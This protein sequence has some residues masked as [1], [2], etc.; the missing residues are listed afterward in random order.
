MAGTP[1]SYT[2]DPRVRDRLHYHNIDRVQPDDVIV[3]SYGGAGQTLLANILLEIGLNYVNPATEVLLPD[4]G[5]VPAEE[6][7]S[8]RGRFAAVHA[9]DNAGTTGSGRWGPRLVK[10]HLF[11][12]EFSGRDFAGVWLLVRDPRDALYS[13]YRF[14]Q[15]FAEVPW[16]FVPDSFEEFLRTDDQTGRRPVNDWTT[17]YL[18]WARRAERCRF[19]TVTR[20]EDLKRDGVA[21]VR[22]ALRALGVEVPEADLERAVEASGFE[23]MRAHEDS[24]AALDRDKVNARI[25]R[26]GAVEGWREWMTPDLAE[27]FSGDETASV[28]AY[29]GYQLPTRR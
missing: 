13:F 10:T 9:R 6:S 23:R 4:G 11:P 28:A 17:F 1:S 21:T 7:L 24:V 22:T 15:E 2:N 26:K 5:S 29:F 18:T 27:C 14:R 3:A 20:F 19:S 25:M 16:E 8:Y 12:E